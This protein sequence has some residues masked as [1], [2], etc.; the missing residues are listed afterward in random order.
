M[1]YI[2]DHLNDTLPA[3]A[4]FIKSILLLCGHS[5]I[6]NITEHRTKNFHK[7]KSKYTDALYK[8]H[9]QN[10][11]EIYSD[12]YSHKFDVCLTVHN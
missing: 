8:H 11:T 1:T 4:V 9:Y 3:R 6:E 10:F 12:S 5:G 2:M 7:M